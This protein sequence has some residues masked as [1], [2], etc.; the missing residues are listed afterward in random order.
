MSD[1]SRHSPPP[2]R[3][4]GGGEGKDAAAAFM[5]PPSLPSPAREEGVS[6]L[7]GYRRADGRLGI[8]NYVL[9]VYLVECAHHVARKIAEPYQERGAQLIGFPGCYPSAYAHR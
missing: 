7:R 5:L 2:L 8:R 9:V 1:A 3:G 6:Q 4:R